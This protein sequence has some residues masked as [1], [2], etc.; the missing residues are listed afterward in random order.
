MTDYRINLHVEIN[1]SSGIYLVNSKLFVLIF[2]AGTIVWYG[3]GVRFTKQLS[4]NLGLR[5]F[6][7]EKFTLIPF[8]KISQ[9]IPKSKFKQNNVNSIG[10]LSQNQTCISPIF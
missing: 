9:K 4:K 7:S 2:A 3:P 1:T 8:H 5:S 10:V 6:V